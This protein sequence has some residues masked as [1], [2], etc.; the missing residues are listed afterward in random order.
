[1]FDPAAGWCAIE[2]LVDDVGIATVLANCDRLLAR[3]AAD[4]LP[5]DKPAS[6]TRHLVDLAARSDAVA[7]I[8]AS[9]TLTTIVSE[10]LGGVPADPE[11]SLRSPQPGYGGQRLHAD[12]LPLTSSDEA[13]R[14]VTAIVALCDFTPLNGA[15]RVV[16]GSHRRP[17]LQRVAGRLEHHADEITLCGPAGTA[18]IFSGH[19]LHS[20][21]ANRSA[22]GRPALQI[23]WR[24][25]ST[26]S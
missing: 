17:D 19:M 11:V 23:V 26:T 25:G 24:S 9:P 22:A 4:R 1:M 16:P 21:T 12:D 2:G 18:F 7:E 20:G 13:P 15:T 14:V 10:I 6:G 8:V 3:P 5:G